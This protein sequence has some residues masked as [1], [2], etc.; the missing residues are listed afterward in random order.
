[1]KQTPDGIIS[2]SLAGI[3]GGFITANLLAIAIKTLLPMTDVNAVIT[4]MLVSFALYCAAAIWA[5]AAKSA[6]VAWKGLLMASALALMIWGG[7][8]LL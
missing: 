7:V 6:L 3:I 1:M 8:S 5:F 2:R 4:A